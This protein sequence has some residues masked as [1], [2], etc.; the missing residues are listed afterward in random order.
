MRHYFAVLL[1]LF[2]LGIPWFALT[3]PDTFNNFLINVSEVSDQFASVIL[4]HNPK[5]IDAIKSKYIAA[6]NAKSDKKVRILIVPGHEPSY[7]GAEL[8]TLKERDMTVILGKSLQQLLQNNNHYQVFITRDAELWNPSFGT[9]FKNGWTDIIAW[10]KAHHREKSHLISLGAL[11][12]TVPTV[13]HNDVPTE[14]ALRLYGITKWA[15]ENDIDIIIHIHFN[16]YNRQSQNGAGKY[17]GFSIYVPEIQYYNSSTTK[18]IA[19]SIFRRLAKY[20][21]VSNFPGESTGIIEESD[22]I[23]V[24][25][26]NTSDAAS[27]LIE[28]GYIYEQQFTNSSLRD[29]AL[30][31]MAFQT[32]LG[33]QD[34]FDVKNVVNN[35]SAFD[36]LLIPHEWRNVLSDTSTPSS[37]I[38]ALQTALVIDGVYPPNNRSLNDCPRSGSIGPCTLSALETFQ[39]KY[40]ITD[41]KGIVG[42]KTRSVLNSRFGMQNVK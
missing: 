5:T 27:M 38:V 13:I 6:N 18:A 22:L 26:N 40:G 9:Y 20:N 24:G 42:P 16:D 1:A 14:V 29:T 2:L 7:G 25:V 10:N 19:S 37:D 35:A 34:F 31:D 23:A 8:G 32:Y 12:Q 17:S 33:L 4:S 11:K 30:K 21:P 28:Y 3:Y 41:E 39:K 36:T 15:N